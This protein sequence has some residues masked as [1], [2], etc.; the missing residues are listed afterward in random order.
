M[1]R[2]K[3]AD[4]KPLSIRLDAATR[5]RLEALQNTMIPGLDAT[6]AQVVRAAL[7]RGIESLEEGAPQRKGKTR[8]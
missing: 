7:T 4:G 2:P 8:R 1:G 6:L 5:E 3:I